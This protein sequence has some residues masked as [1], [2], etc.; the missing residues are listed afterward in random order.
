MKQKDSPIWQARKEQGYTCRKLGNALNMSP[1]RI[2]EIE[3]GRC[4]PT[5]K[6]LDKIYNYLG[7][8]QMRQRT[9]KPTHPAEV[10]IEQYMK[11]LGITAERLAKHLNYDKEMIYGLLEHK[12]EVTADIALRLSMAF[13]TTPELWLNMQN[14]YDLYKAKELL[15]EFDAE[16]SPY[17]IPIKKMEG[18]E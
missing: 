11:P 6:E 12:I 15:D 1:S 13:D 10:I 8:R 2:S 9:R 5:E 14:K 7:I 16:Y 4:Q 3:L 17:W 18:L